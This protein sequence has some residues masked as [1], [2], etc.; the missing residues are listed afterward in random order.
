MFLPLHWQSG[1]DALCCV[2]YSG[3]IAAE[4]CWQFTN[5]GARQR[6]VGWEA[7]KVVDTIERDAGI[8]KDR[9]VAHVTCCEMRRGHKSEGLELVEGFPIC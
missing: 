5:G 9:L 2:C 3:I 4:V 8:V 6:Q 7:G 1:E